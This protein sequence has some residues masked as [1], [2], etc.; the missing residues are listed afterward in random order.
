MISSLFWSL[1]RC[2][3]RMQRSSRVL[4]LELGTEN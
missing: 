4:Q 1:S 3:Y 2:R